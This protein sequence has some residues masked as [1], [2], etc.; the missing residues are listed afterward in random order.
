MQQLNT[1][2]GELSSLREV[3]LPTV[4]SYHDNSYHD[5]SEDLLDNERYTVIMYFL[6]WLS[7]L[8]LEFDNFWRRG[9]EGGKVCVGEFEGGRWGRIAGHFGTLFALSVLNMWP[10]W[11]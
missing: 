11:S 6:G 4:D 8:L 5:N 3:T 7:L 10:I 2:R 1:R 9:Q